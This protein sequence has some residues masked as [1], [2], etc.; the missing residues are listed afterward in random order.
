MEYVPFIGR[1]TENVIDLIRAEVVIG[2]LAV[3]VVI[4]DIVATDKEI[5][6]LHTPIE[7]NRNEESADLQ[8]DNDYIVCLL[9]YIV[10]MCSVRLV[11]KER[12][13]FPFLLN[14]LTTASEDT[15]I[16]SA[17]DP[18]AR[19]IIILKLS[20]YLCTHQNTCFKAGNLWAR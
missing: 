16:L 11:S 8:S 5:A 19:G 17:A 13:C 18:V 2:V 7:M 6:P 1:K 9:A 15:N 4:V 14:P 10:L 20:H 3:N 12:N